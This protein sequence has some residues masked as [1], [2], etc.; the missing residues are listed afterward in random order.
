MVAFLLGGFL[1]KFLTQ[2]VSKYFKYR[3]KYLNEIDST[4]NYPYYY[5]YRNDILSLFNKSKALLYRYRPSVPIVYI[6]GTQKPFQFHGDRW[7]N[8]LKENEGCEAYGME[9]GHWIMNKY[10][11]FLNELIRRRL[12]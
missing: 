8:Y 2:S 4:R 6:Y 1:G 7:L 12:K 9:T 10:A 5:L 3:P 11:S